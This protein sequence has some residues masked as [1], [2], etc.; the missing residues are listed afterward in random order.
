M[1]DAQSGAEPKLTPADVRRVCGN[2]AE[3]KVEEI[4]ATGGDIGL[5]EEATAWASGDN[6]TTS[7]RHLPPHGAAARMSEILMTGDTPG[8]DV[9]D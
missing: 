7:R 1:T 4:L 6:E 2:F 3:W 8:E 9:P 5:L